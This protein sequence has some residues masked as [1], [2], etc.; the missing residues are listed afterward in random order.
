MVL[1]DGALGKQLG[2]QGGALMNRISALPKGSQRANLFFPSY[3]N[4]MRC[5]LL[6]TRKR[7]LMKA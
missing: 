2:H 4:T 3:E 1:E 5:Q 7:V 6:S